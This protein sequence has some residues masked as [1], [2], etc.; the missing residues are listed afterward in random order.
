MKI[1]KYLSYLLLA[2]SAIIIVLFYVNGGSDSM[3][4]L[5]LNWAYVLFALC[6]V[7]AI[8]LP[9][10]F[11]SGKGVKGTLVKVG[12]FAVVALIAYLASSSAPLDLPMSPEP[13]AGDL[14]FADAALLMTVIL[15]VIAACSLVIGAVVNSIK[16]R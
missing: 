9:I 6:V 8:C 1:V 2:V 7:G 14:K 15:I 16:N 3:V 13:S 4:T 11:G 5:L 10:F 12:A